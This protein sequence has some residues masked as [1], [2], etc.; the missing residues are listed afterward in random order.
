M[1]LAICLIHNRTAPQN[2][3]QI[4]TI[5]ALVVPNYLPPGATADDYDAVYY[6]IS[7]LAVEH[8]ARFYQCVPFG[9]NQPNNMG[10]L[11][12]HNVIYGVR[13]EN[14]TGTHPRF[15]NWCIKRAC[16]YGAD[17]VALVTD[18]AQFTVTGLAL[19]IARLVNR[20]VLVLPLWGLAVA[21]RLFPLVGQ[22]REDQNA[23]DSLADLR[24]RIVA[25]G[26]ETD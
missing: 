24:D 9:V 18:H 21:C 3:N 2:R 11:D 4:T 25:A 6:T 10:L 7:G 15:R 16:D 23:T 22:F 5:A 19:Q 13:D 17:V 20:R 14:K 12:S 8:V 1:N 26:W